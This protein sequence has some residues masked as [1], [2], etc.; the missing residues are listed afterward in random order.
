MMGENNMVNLTINTSVPVVKTDTVIY[1]KDILISF[2]R[3]ADGLLYVAKQFKKNINY[4][5]IL[6][7]QLIQPDIKLRKK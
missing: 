2:Y 7:T 1:N 6:I 4:K 5:E 3:S